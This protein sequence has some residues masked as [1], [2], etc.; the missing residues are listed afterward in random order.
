MGFEGA[1]LNICQINIWRESP[2]TAGL[3]TLRSKF[4]GQDCA[5]YPSLP[6]I[7][8]VLL[9]NSPAWIFFVCF[10]SR[11]TKCTE[12]YCT[13]IETFVWILTRSSITHLLLSIFA[14][15][16]V[17]ISLASLQLD[18]IMA[19]LHWIED[20]QRFYN[21]VDSFSGEW[22]SCYVLY[23]FQNKF[24]VSDRPDKKKCIPRTVSY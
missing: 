3:W 22:G 13:D 8:H 15:A 1:P 10:R 14:L 11:L 5:I 17:V 2:P 9:R 23:L 20:L 12:M 21:R 6:V 24:A 7:W 19:F 16:E 18:T 4:K